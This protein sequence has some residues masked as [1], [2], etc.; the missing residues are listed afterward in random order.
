MDLR[1]ELSNV[2]KTKKEIV[3]TYL[4]IKSE[5]SEINNKVI[6]NCFYYIIDNIDNDMIIDFDNLNSIYDFSESEYSESMDYIVYN[7][8]FMIKTDLINNIDLNN[9]KKTFMDFVVKFNQF[10]I[11]QLDI[12]NN[13]I[14]M[15]DYF[16]TNSEL[17]KLINDNDIDYDEYMEYLESIKSF[18]DSLY[19]CLKGIKKDYENY[20]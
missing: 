9:P 10:I 6:Y 8:E 3:N 13:N 20:L 2:Q 15:S 1:N 16:Y 4:C 17:E 12:K 5:L 11:N 18:Y 7:S 14:D 19:D